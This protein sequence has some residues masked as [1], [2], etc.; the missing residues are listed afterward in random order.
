[1]TTRRTYLRAVGLL[2]AGGVSALAGCGAR[3]QTP[4]TDDSPSP[5]DDGF[6]PNEPDYKGWFKGVSNYEGTLDLRGQDRVSIQVGSKGNMGAYSFEPAA[7]AI[8]PGTTVVWE[9][10]GQGGVHNV[11]AERGAFDSGAVVE[12]KGH[13]F[14]HIFADPG[15]FTY[16]CEPHRT[17]GM[18]G[19]VFVALGTPGS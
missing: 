15:V 14:E 18:R 4:P 1:M 9:W 6:V 19:A 10:T 12:T 3:A 13:T 17:M 5:V 7:V 2:A 11:V 16:V 8:S